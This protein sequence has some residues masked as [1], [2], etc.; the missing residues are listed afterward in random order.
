MC[1]TKSKSKSESNLSQKSEKSTFYLS[2]F[3]KTID[4]MHKIIRETISKSE[5]INWDDYFMS[6]AFLISSR[7]PCTRL[8]VGCVIVKNNRIISAGYNGFLPGAKH[9]SIVK[10]NHEQATI[11]AEQ[12]AV[13]DCAHRGV[14]TEGSTAYITHHPCINCFKILIASGVNKIIYAED[15]NNDL[16]IY[17]MIKTLDTGIHMVKL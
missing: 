15:Y 11:H 7:S 14:S 17:E 4:K 5:R 6:T 10:D 13:S 1:E 3:T 8:H 12:N 2:I 9:V 16:N